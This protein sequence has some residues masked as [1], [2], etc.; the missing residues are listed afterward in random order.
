MQNIR[1]ESVHGD[2]TSLSECETI[3]KE[4]IGIGQSGILNELLRYKNSF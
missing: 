1:N 3:R 4:V 2:T